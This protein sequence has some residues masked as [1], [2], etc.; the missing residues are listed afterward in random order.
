MRAKGR[1]LGSSGV[2]ATKGG[3]MWDRGN[4]EATDAGGTM[5]SGGED[6]ASEAGDQG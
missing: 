1:G 2:V 6:G 5:D 3:G 4:M